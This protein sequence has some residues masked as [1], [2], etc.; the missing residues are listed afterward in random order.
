MAGKF[1]AIAS[2]LWSEEE[3]IQK[4]LRELS[5]KTDLGFYNLILSG[6]EECLVVLKARPAK[7][8]KSKRLDNDTNFGLWTMIE[9]RAGGKLDM[10]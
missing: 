5:D 10:K 8:K 2:E 3:E 9:T 6:C 1:E 4:E 7:A